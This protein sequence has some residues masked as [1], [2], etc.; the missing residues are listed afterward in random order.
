MSA[1]GVILAAGLGSRLRPLTETLPK[2]LVPMG[3]TT[4]LA[5]ALRS[6]GSAG[7]PTVVVVVGHHR[8]L[9][10]QEAARVCAGEAAPAVRCVVNEDYATTG[11]AASLIAGLSELER[12][13]GYDEVIVAEGDIWF[14]ACVVQRLAAVP[15]AHVVA[16]DAP[17]VGGDGSL[18][19]LRPD[20]RVSS[21]HFLSDG[22]PRPELTAGRTFRLGNIY[23]FRSPGWDSVL[24]PA[25]RTGV[26]ERPELPLEMALGDLCARSSLAITGVPVSDCRWWEIDT[27]GDLVAA[28]AR[29]LKKMPADQAARLGREVAGDDGRC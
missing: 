5:Q 21:W 6:L 13:G 17:G 12:I 18:V 24:L 22:G 25:L 4:L 28:T 9:V 26:A 11:T 14:D 7:V 23:R 29:C 19:T 10:A 3:K 27:A 15:D 2:C 8:Q 16:V 20:Q 1:S